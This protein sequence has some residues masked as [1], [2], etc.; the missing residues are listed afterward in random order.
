MVEDLSSLHH[1]LIICPPYFVSSQKP[2]TLL[3]RLASLGSTVTDSYTDVNGSNDVNKGCKNVLS[4]HSYNNS[5]L[6]SSLCHIQRFYHSELSCKKVIIMVLNI[7][8]GT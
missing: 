5:C 2:L 8:N 6:K 3:P 4:G 1:P 7:K